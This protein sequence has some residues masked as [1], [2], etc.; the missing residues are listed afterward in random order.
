MSQRVT[1]YWVEPQECCDPAWEAA[2][3]RF[4]TAAEETE[5][6]LRRLRGFGVEAWAREAQVVEIFCGRGSGLAAWRQLGFSNLEGVDLSENLLNACG[7][8]ARLYLGDCRA[9]KFPDA[10]RD[11]ICVQGGLHH[12]ALLPDD[13][14]RTVAEVR[15]VLRPGGRF[16]VVEPWSTPFLTAVHAACRLRW[17]R[18]ASAKLDALGCMIE[19]ER[20][21]YFRWLSHSTDIWTE[22]TRGFDTESKRVAWGK[23]SWVGRKPVA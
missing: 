4:E 23:L 14:R 11:I 15:R 20:E 12:L 1:E 10:S 2:Y 5:K 22:L 8:E 17:L 7:G 9:L 21:T 3:T 16:V 13:L 19:H 18:G 6:F